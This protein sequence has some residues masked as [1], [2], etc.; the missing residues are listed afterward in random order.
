[1]NVAVDNTSIILN[2]ANIKFIHMNNKVERRQNGRTW[3]AS[4][5]KCGASL[6]KCGTTS[7]C[8]AS[9]YKCG[10][11]WF[12]RAGIYVGRLGTY[13]GR[14]GINVGRAGWGELVLGRIDWHPISQ[15]YLV[16]Q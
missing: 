9:W 11:S 2:V 10:A 1:M 8:G 14:V 3:W 6:Y 13:M 4:C 16:T 15:V 12:G 7:K 5:Y